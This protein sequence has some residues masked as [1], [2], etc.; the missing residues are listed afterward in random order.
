[1]ASISAPK[2][3]LHDFYPAWIITRREVRDQFRDWRIIFPV[4]GLTLVFPF[5][6]NW[7]AQ[8]ILNFVNQYGA[9]LIGERLVPFLLMIVGFFPISVSLV[10]ALESFVGEKERSSIEP[11]LNTPL[12]DWQL[13]LGKLLAATVPPLLSSFLGMVVYLTGLAINHIPWPEPVMMIQIFSLTTV[14]AVMMVSGAVVVSAQAT[15]VR[16]ANLLASFIIIPSAFLIQ[17]EALVMFWGNFDTL[18]WVVFGVLVLT[19]LLVRVGLA[20]FRREELLG[21]E[22]DVL[23]LSWGWKVFRTAF[24]GGARNPVQWYRQVVSQTLRRLLLPALLVT[25]IVIAGL[26]IGNQ[27]VDR[28]PFLLEQAGIM[29]ISK[30]DIHDVLKSWPLTSSASVMLVWWQNVRVL[31]LAMILGIF[32]FGVVGVMPLLATTAIAGY[33]FG[34]L[35]RVGL[36]VVP[37]VVG[38][39]LPHGIIEIPAAILATAAVLHSGAVL[40][41]PVQGKTTGEVWLEALADWAKVMVGVVIPLLLLAAVIEVWVTPQVALLV[42]S[43]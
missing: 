5:I 2:N 40:A 37:L 28:F 39:I 11:L 27:Q 34:A 21:R 16:S 26:L 4:L 17:W 42:L 19:V 6:M 12:K 1:M 3:V 25:G 7:T 24:T 29:D 10:I 18:W 32:S 13:Y 31:L 43:R 30:A 36:P 15:S 33:L 8:K 22:I 20:Q 41:K 38:L 23:R 9:T 14:Q 35:G